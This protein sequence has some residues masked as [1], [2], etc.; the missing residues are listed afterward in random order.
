MA[1]S[2]VLLAVCAFVAAMGAGADAARAMPV[3][4]LRLRCDTHTRCVRGKWRRPG[5]MPKRIAG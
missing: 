5:A 2:A 3:R 4:R 1:R